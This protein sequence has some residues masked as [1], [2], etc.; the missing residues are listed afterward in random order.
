M[1]RH[2]EVPQF[3]E[4]RAGSFVHLPNFFRQ[5]TRLEENLM[6]VTRLARLG[7]GNAGMSDIGKKDDADFMCV[8][9]LGAIHI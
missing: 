8:R 9:E 7:A 1:L 3:S 5:M 4:P 6:K 2:I